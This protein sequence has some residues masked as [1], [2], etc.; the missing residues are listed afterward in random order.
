MIKLIPKHEIDTI[1]PLISEWVDAAKGLGLSYSNDDIKEACKTRWDLRLIY[2]DELKGFLISQIYEAPQCRVCYAP[3]LGGKDLAE[4]VGEAFDEFKTYLKT[5]GV[6]Q[7][8]FIGRKA[9]QKLVKAD[10]EQSFYLMTL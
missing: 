6:S 7:Y 10:S 8:S 5:H 4:W 2:T 1:W 9:W 3:Y